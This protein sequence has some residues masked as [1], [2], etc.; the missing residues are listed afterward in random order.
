MDGLLIDSEPLWQ[1]AEKE[2]YSSVG[3]ELTEEYIV[4]MMGRP[5]IE[6]A[7]SL[8]VT[9]MAWSISRRSG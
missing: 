2:T 4:K 6:N 3:I 1:R 8:R 7:R 9:P 5:P